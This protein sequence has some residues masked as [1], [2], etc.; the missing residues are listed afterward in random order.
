MGGRGSGVP[1]SPEHL[2]KKAKAGRAS[3]AARAAR[4]QVT[5]PDAPASSRVRGLPTNKPATLA[6]YDRVLGRP[7]SWNA[8][9]KREEVQGEILANEARNDERQVARGKRFT[10]EQIEARDQRFE[11]AI[12][13]GLAE[14]PDLAASLVTPDKKDAARA[15]LKDWV[16]AF[17]HQ[18]AEAI[19]ATA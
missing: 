14:L 8:A 7:T 18:L 3:A 16:A 4:E 5:A 2:A 12:V 19:R 6:D 15:R 1:S 11:E 10:R 17:R 13:K 9:K